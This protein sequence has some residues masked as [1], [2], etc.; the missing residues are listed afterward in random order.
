MAW[1]VAASRIAGDQF[2]FGAANF[3]SNESRARWSRAGGASDQFAVGFLP[4][5]E[6]L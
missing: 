3:N 2:Y 5:I 6:S 1:H 4:L